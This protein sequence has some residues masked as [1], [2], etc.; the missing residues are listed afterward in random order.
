[1]PGPSEG[2][3]GAFAFD[4]ATFAPT[5]KLIYGAPGR[6]LSIELAQ[7]LGLPLPVVAAA[8]GFLSDDQKK[9][10]AAAIAALPDASAAAAASGTAATKR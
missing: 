4:A 8:R 9:K 1:M 10:L 7:R 3:F 2:V 6:S 5:Y